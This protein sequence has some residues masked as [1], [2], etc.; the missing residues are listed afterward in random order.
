MRELCDTG[1]LSSRLR[2]IVVSH[3]Q[4]DADGAYRAMWA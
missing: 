4:H 1:F 2:Q 3:W